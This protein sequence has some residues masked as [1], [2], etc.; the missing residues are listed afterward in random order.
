MYLIRVLSA[1]YCHFL[2][3]V[4]LALIINAFTKDL[5]VFFCTDC[6]IPGRTTTR[7]SNGH[8]RQRTD[9]GC[10]KGIVAMYR[11]VRGAQGDDQ[12]ALGKQQRKT[13]IYI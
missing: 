7:I 9:I 12:V 10:L 13:S 5:D 2:T 8:S 11:A 6:A 4:Y 1:L 3:L